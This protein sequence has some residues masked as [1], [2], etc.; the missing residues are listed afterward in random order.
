MPDA[1]V[2][3]HE[4]RMPPVSGLKDEDRETALQIWVKSGRKLE[5][6]R[7]MTPRYRNVLVQTML[8]AADLEVSTITMYYTPLVKAPTLEAKMAVASA[9]Q[10]E[11]GHAQVMYRMLEDFGYNT[12]EL[13]FERDPTEFK[14]FYL[15]QHDIP[16]YIQCVV[17]MLLGDRAGYTT[18][19][20]LEESCSYGPYARS[21]RKVNFEEQFHVAHG[22]KWTK[23]YWNLSPE[24]RKRV[25]EAIDFVFPNAVMW[26]GT[27]DTMKKRVDQLSYKIR[28]QS[29]DELRQ[30]WL[31]EVVPFCESI[32]IRVPA[33]FDADKGCYVLDY[34]M[35]ILLNEETGK[36]DYKTTTWEEQFE[37]WR[38]GGPT[39]VSGFKRL[40]EEHWGSALW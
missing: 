19:R 26:F 13:I 14:T 8:I 21:L 30:R 33:H 7:E 12:H 3:N 24:T 5:D 36:W 37:Q 29:N 18:T 23:F 1:A 9:M 2:A 31:N 28:G 35:P 40:Q 4:N 32:G 38:K 6:D 27:P 10:D 11:L 17:Y 22:E 20:D 25:Q 34:E 15:T 39:K 16:D